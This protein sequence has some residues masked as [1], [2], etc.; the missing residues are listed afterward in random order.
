MSSSS[1][2]TT[3]PAL[4]VFMR[5]SDDTFILVNMAFVRMIS[6]QTNGVLRLQFGPAGN[7]HVDVKSVTIAQLQEAMPS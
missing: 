2:V 6:Q 5:A 7:D 1:N 4:R 3:R